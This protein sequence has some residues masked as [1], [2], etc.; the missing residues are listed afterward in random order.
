MAFVGALALLEGSAMAK[1]EYGTNV[2]TAAGA[3]VLQ[4]RIKE[5]EKEVARLNSQIKTQQY[6][7]VWLDVPEAFEKESENAIPI[8][9]E[10][11]SKAIRNDDGKPTHILIEGDNYHALTCLSYTHRG[12]IDVIY[13][14]P[15]YNT[16]S[17]GFTYKDK[18]VLD[19]FPDGQKIEKDHPLRHSAWLS[20][21]EKRLRLAKN[22]LRDNGVIFISINEEEYANLKLLLDLIFNESNYITTFTVKVRHEDRILKG[23][24]PI[25]ETTEFLLMYQRSEKFKIQKRKVDNSSPSEYVYKIKELTEP[26]EV[27]E[28]GGK[29]VEVF[30][31]GQYEIEKHN[32]SFDN[33]KKIN[34]RGTIKAGNSSGRFHMTF[35]E[36]RKND[37][38]VLYKVPGIGDDGLGYR[39]FLSRANAKKA[40]GFYFQGAPLDRQDIREIPYP[41]FLDF[42][43]EFNAV[44]TE[45][46]VA[47]DGGK[48]PI[49]FIK[50]LLEIA[51]DSKSIRVLDFFAGSGSTLHA[52]ADLNQDNGSRQ[53]IIV[54]RADLTYEMKNGVEKALKG[55][56]NAFNA[57]FRDIASIAYRR[58]KNAVCGYTDGSGARFNALGGSLKY[59]RTAFVGENDAAKA[60][61]EDREALSRKAGCLLG[62]AENTLEETA[63]G[64]CWQVFTDG[65]DRMTGVYFSGDASE[66]DEFVA[67]LEAFR[68][69]SRLNCVA[70]YFFCWD[71]AASFANEFRSTKRID[72]KPIPEPILKVY[73]ELNK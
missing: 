25:H 7:L 64:R 68:D 1:T 46:G 36:P 10:D 35:L 69:A 2:Q 17:D 63:A 33:L 72:V 66:M 27:L 61:D 15:P 67:H 8:L 28:L 41:N 51:T 48:K 39:Y 65:G 6:G 58:A 56:E 20:F 47:F 55:C 38:N 59:Y 3:A 50:K 34:I 12:K 24:K 14:D 26:S 60:N 52:V 19:K 4:E 62:L 9:E 70:A 32:P 21:M 11:K 23:D 22:L 18:R 37:F 73:R 31:P 44:G 5:L 43:A 42:E 71:D 30:R 16:G 45:G 54:Q 49:A 13:I 40:N 29:S 57:G 53:A